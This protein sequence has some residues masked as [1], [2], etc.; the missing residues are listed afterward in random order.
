MSAICQQ[1]TT[2]ECS[3]FNVFGCVSSNTLQLISLFCQYCSPF[4][5]FP[6]TFLPHLPKSSKKFENHFLASKIR[7]CL[8]NK[9]QQKNLDK[10]TTVATHTHYSQRRSI[11]K[12]G[13]YT[14]HQVLSGMSGFDKFSKLRF[15]RI[16]RKNWAENQDA[17]KLPLMLCWV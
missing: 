12:P 4:I 9:N 15:F 6:Y 7:Q 16:R 10:N 3:F 5:A 8:S 14:E 2:S 11:Q 17:M 1:D 13:F